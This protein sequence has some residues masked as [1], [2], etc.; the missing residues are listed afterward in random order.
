MYD[1]TAHGLLA[2]TAW[3]RLRQLLNALLHRELIKTMRLAQEGWDDLRR[4]EDVER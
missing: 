4:A 3:H 1:A 2:E